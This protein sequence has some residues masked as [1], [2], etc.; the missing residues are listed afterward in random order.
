MHEDRK[1]APVEAA[2]PISEPGTRGLV[3]ASPVTGLA[4]AEIQCWRLAC[5]LA[6]IDRSPGSDRHELALRIVARSR[7]TSVLDRPAS[8]VAADILAEL[9]QDITTGRTANAA[10]AP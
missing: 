10:S 7:E 8:V 1:P 6:A 5:L 9:A 3:Q 2:P 4:M